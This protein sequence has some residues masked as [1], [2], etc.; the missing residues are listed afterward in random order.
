M[1]LELVSE[2]MSNN[3]H[4]I[5]GLPKSSVNLICINLG[6]IIDFSKSETTDGSELVMRGNIEYLIDKIS[7]P[8]L[9]IQILQVVNLAFNLFNLIQLVGVFSL[10]VINF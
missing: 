3:G 8:M 7:L 6:N 2:S 10:I 9:L 4:Q 1:V 5:S